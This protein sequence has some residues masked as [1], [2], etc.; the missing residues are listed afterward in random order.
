[1]RKILIKIIFVMVVFALVLTPIN[2]SAK[3]SPKQYYK[4]L[5]IVAEKSSDETTKCSTSYKKSGGKNVYIVNFKS[6][7]LTAAHFRLAKAYY[8]DTYKKLRNSTKKS[9]KDLYKL[10]KKNVTGKTVV[11]VNLKSK[12]NKKII[13]AKNGKITYDYCE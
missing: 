13:T 6:A 3:V 9:S 11:Y 2:V 4:V 7:Q 12:D 1:M 10:T 5:K 8:P